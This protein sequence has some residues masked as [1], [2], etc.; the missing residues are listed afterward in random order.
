MPIHV[1][2]TQGTLDLVALQHLHWHDRCI[3]HHIT[4]HLAMEDLQ[5]PIVT[6]ICKQWEAA[7]MIL[8]S[9]DGLRVN[10]IVLYGQ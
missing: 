8:D 10:L 2:N 3:L 7:L 5:S 1:H 4:D 9:S 6:S